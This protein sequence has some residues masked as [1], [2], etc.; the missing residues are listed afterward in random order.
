MVA[1][2][3]VVTSKAKRVWII[4]A[5]ASHSDSNGHFPT[6]LE[7]PATARSFGFLR[8]RNGE[9]T[10]LTQL[11]RYLEDRHFGDLNSPKARID[12]EAVL[13]LLDA[14]IGISS[15]A[16]LQGAREFALG[17][18]RKTIRRLHKEAHKSNGEYAKLANELGARDSLIT[19]NWDHLL[20]DA[21]QRPLFL[22]GLGGENA[23]A[24]SF[25]E[26][27]YGR[28][29]SEFTGY[30]E[31]TINGIGIKSPVGSA[32]PGPG[33]FIKAHG[34]IDWYACANTACRAYGRLFPSLREKPPMCGE[35]RELVET[36][37]VPPTL[38]KRLRELAPIRRLWTAAA[39]EVRRATEIIVWGYRLP[40]TDFLAEWLFRQANAI[41]LRALILINP[42][43][44]A[45]GKR[46]RV[47]N[48]FVSR[49]QDV[50]GA[51]PNGIDLELY[52]SF[53]AYS[54]KTPFA[55]GHR[56][57]VG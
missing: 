44:R 31:Q 14:D 37:I 28:F 9:E 30:G 24:F 7:L 50:V 56:K 15:R 46:D 8:R 42:E 1:S 49:F 36:I 48:E 43:I 52:Q 20:D 27:L 5:G 38:N 4:G 41:R 55:P 18:L 26:T 29:L 3:S 17:L 32:S 21:L 16:R 12:L 2:R 40:P 19:F 54:A 47:N 39:S 6:L 13:T 35:C 51:L 10:G 11:A 25:E 23:R 33:R 22:E 45:A 57:G 53:A 34:S